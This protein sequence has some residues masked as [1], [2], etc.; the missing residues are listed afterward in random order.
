ML[1]QL[2]SAVILRPAL[3]QNTASVQINSTH[4]FRPGVSSQA[5]AILMKINVLFFFLSS[6]LILNKYL[7]R[8]MISV[9]VLNGYVMV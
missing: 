3:Y 8:I 6:N 9:Q 7:L 4:K 5:R 2:K 1:F